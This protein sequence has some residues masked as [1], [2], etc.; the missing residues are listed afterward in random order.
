MK[1]VLLFGNANIN[2]YQICFSFPSHIHPLGR[3]I[4]LALPPSF[5]PKMFGLDKTQLR[6]P[7]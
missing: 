7:C 4:N 6:V 5:P 3:P 1:L 2:L